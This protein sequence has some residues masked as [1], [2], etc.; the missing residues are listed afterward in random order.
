MKKLLTLFLTIC[1]TV[2][3]SACGEE[4]KETLRYIPATT[5]EMQAIGAKV[6]DTIDRYLSLDLTEEKATDEVSELYRRIAKMSDDERGYTEEDKY[7]SDNYSLR[8]EIEYVKSGAFSQSYQE[9][10]QSRDIIAFLSGV[11]VSGTV[12][13]PAQIV[14]GDYFGIEEILDTTGIYDMPFSSVFFY[15]LGTDKELSM[16]VTFDIMNGVTPES[17]GEYCSEIIKSLDSNG[18]F[19]S[20]LSISLSQY[21]QRILSLDFWNDFTRVFVHFSEQDGITVTVFID[22]CEKMWDAL[23]KNEIEITSSFVC[24]SDNGVDFTF[25][26]GRWEARV[27]GSESEEPLTDIKDIIKEI[28]KYWEV[29]K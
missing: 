16:T 19:I 6:V 3:I 28:K 11:D 8:R 12:F 4:E 20:D 13:E 14:S 10:K 29:E 18:L 25:I 24:Y 23:Q 21:D 7:S 27:Y 9:L 26:N 5:N 1:I 15:E 2:S 17:F 22:F